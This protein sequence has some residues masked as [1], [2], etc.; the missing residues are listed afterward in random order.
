MAARSCLLCGK[1]LGRIQSGKGEDFCSREH[2]AQYRLRQGMERLAEAN[3]VATVVR[4][5]ESPRQIPIEQLRAKGADAAREFSNAP[6]RPA[7]ADFRAVSLAP[8]PAALPSTTQMMRPMADG[9]AD[10]IALPGPTISIS[11][12]ASVGPASAA[13]LYAHVAPAPAVR[14]LANAAD[15][16][17]RR[18]S[19]V[20]QRLKVRAPLVRA[21]GAAPA[22]CFAG[23]RKIVSKS[24]GRALRVSLS[25][26]FRPPEWKLRGAM[27]AQPGV[28][29]MKWPGAVAA[30]GPRSRPGSPRSCD[31]EAAEL[32]MRIPS[33]PPAIFQGG[34]RWPGPLPAPLRSVDSAA[35]ERTASVPISSP[36][37]RR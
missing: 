13:S 24:K 5:R 25:A 4:R 37:E 7:P 6:W 33:A 34:M 36:E 18:K 15:V 12:K 35:V 17:L 16:S 21:T 20:A 28:A 29:G 2:R 10:P 3:Q 8:A 30:N 27:L 23:P 14:A 26:R 32:E 19:A 9:P 22:V 1:A 11:A 31:I